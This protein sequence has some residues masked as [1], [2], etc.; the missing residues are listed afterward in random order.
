MYV[1]YQMHIRYGLMQQLLTKI[2]EACEIRVFTSFVSQKYYTFYSRGT[3]FSTAICICRVLK[4]KLPCKRR[5][6]NSVNMRP[7]GQRPLVERK[8]DGRYAASVPR[9]GNK[10]TF[11]ARLP[12][13]MQPVRRRRTHRPAQHYCKIH[14]RFVSA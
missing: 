13:T 11:A 1:N 14:L 3:G 9:H 8:L 4:Q 12:H 10:Q 2:N 6:C 5:L 7:I